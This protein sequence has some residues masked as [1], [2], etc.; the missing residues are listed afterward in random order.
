MIDKVFFI[1]HFVSDNKF[2]NE[3]KRFASGPFFR[4][5]CTLR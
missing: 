5:I 2:E 1:S 3:A 4:W